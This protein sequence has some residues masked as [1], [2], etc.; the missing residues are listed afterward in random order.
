MTQFR[1]FGRSL[2]VP[3]TVQIKHELRVLA[4]EEDARV[5]CAL[6]EG[7]A[8]TASWA[9]IAARRAERDTAGGAK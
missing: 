1:R 2:P 3:S 8:V 6:E 9:D 5:R 4:A 7:L